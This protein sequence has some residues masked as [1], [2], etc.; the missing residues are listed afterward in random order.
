MSKRAAVEKEPSALQKDKEGQNIIS[1]IR[2]ASFR[3]AV[4]KSWY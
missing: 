1:S 4:G 2:A 3:Y